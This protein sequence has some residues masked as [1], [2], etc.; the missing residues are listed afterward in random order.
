MNSRISTVLTW[1]N[2]E[3]FNVCSVC[4]FFS[5]CFQPSDSGNS[6]ET[7]QGSRTEGTPEPAAIA[8]SP[9]PPAT[10]QQQQSLLPEEPQP[11]T[12]TSHLYCLSPSLA[13]GPQATASGTACAVQH[14]RTFKNSSCQGSLEIGGVWGKWWK[15]GPPQAVL[16]GV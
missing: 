4:W 11:S 16:I 9:Q 10:Q 12:S 14:Q 15:C 6:A 7:R 8:S 1:L 13:S 3:H 2:I 5:P